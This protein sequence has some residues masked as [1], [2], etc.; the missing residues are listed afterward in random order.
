MQNEREKKNK[1]VGLSS[2]ERSE[3]S[4]LRTKGHSM[5]DIAKVLGR[6]PNTVSYEI[7]HNSVTA[8]GADEPTYDPL[9]AKQKARV[10]RRSRRH[11][12]QKI[13]QHPSLRAF[14][15][16]KLE[17]HDW[18]PDAIAGYLTR[19]TQNPCHP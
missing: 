13:E 6:S 4:I 8:E 3:I 16:D 5:R 18:S 2:A 10:S 11:Q 9:K 7:K 12:W 15:I 19:L 14:V 1:F 17:T